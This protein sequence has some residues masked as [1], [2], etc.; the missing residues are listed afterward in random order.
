MKEIE[1]MRD[2]FYRAHYNTSFSPEV[3][4]DS[5]VRDFSSEL[6]S[7]L[8]E[9][10]DNAGNYKEKYL[11]HLRTWASRK[12]SCLSVMITG[13]AN[14]PTARNRK[15]NDAE[16]R[17]WRE[18][19]EWRDR[20][21]KRAFREPTKTP[22]E[23]IDA[24]LAEYEKAKEAHEMMIGINKIVRKKISNAEKKALLIEEWGLLESVAEKIISPDCM[25]G[26]GFHSFELTNSNGK[27]KRLQEKVITMRYRIE[28]RDAF[29]A[30]TFPGGSISIENDR[31][32]IIHEEK[33]PRDT[34]D[35]LKARGFHWSPKHG[36]WCRKHTANAIATAKEICGVK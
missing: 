16:S 4:A 36:S 33:P 31:V 27:L 3:R 13:P 20:Y 32:I 24:A 17:A 29:E 23:E 2:T 11:S 10:G 21:I 5:C 9:L 14:F 19:R 30:I 34:I 7:D 22:E 8:V 1:A 26:I 6:M 25:G 18:F 15:A 28:R 35:A 12:A